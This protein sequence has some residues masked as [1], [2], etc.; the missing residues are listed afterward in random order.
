MYDLLVLENFFF[1]NYNQL[2]LK[3]FSYLKPYNCLGKKKEIDFE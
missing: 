2:Q 3:I 1:F